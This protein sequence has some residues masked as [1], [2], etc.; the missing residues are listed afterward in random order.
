VEFG[1]LVLWYLVLAHYRNERNWALPSLVVYRLCGVLRDYGGLM[2]YCV[3][4]TQVCSNRPRNAV[5]V[6]VGT[7]SAAST[8]IIW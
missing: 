5:V 4:H 3:Q 6:S 1:V 7:V 8:D 2:L